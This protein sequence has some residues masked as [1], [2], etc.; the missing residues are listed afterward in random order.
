VDNVEGYWPEKVA[1]CREEMRQIIHANV[2][3]SRL[4]IY[5]DLLDY[6]T[7]NIIEHILEFAIWGPRHGHLAMLGHLLPYARRLEG[8]ALVELTEC[9]VIAPILHA[10]MNVL[11]NLK[12]LKIMSIDLMH[13]ERTMVELASFIRSRRQLRR[14]LSPRRAPFVTYTFSKDWI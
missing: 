10:N 11:L 2:H 4:T 6:I 8:L 14:Y 13:D 5:S 7:P 3:L 12:A 9:H 1:E